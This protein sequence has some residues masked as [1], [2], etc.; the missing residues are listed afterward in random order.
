[1]NSD[2][3]NNYYN[4]IQKTKEKFYESHRKHTIFKNNQK[5][6][7]TQHISNELDLQKMIQCTA[8]VVPNTNIVYYNYMIFKT[9]GNDENHLIVYDYLVNL[10]SSILENYSTFEFHIN[11]KSFTI[12]ACQRYYH[13]ICSSFDDNTFFTDKM[14]KMVVYYTP[15]IIDQLTKILYKSIKDVIPKV[16]YCHKESEERIKVLFDM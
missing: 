8:F 6:Q 12:S 14:S 1:M 2:E 7:C 3:R 11:L 10:V 4:E 15:N 5:L 16:E 13:M 9:Y